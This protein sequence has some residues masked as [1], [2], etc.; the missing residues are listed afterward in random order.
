[1]HL[2]HHIHNIIPHLKHQRAG[3]IQG[4]K[5]YNQTSGIRYHS[6]P[7]GVDIIKGKR[8]CTQVGVP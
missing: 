7:G 2:E 8:P 5:I 3:F 1:M 4:H 6:G